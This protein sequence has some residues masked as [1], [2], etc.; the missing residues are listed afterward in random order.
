MQPIQVLGTLPVEVRYGDYVGTHKLRVVRGNVLNL[1]RRDWLEHIRL[2]W[3]SIKALNVHNSSLSV[4]Q[5]IKKHAPVFEPGL[6]TMKNFT[7]KLHLKEGARPCFFRSRPVFVLK[8]AVEQ[9]ITR[10]VNNDT[11]RPV[12]YS[13]WAAPIV[14]VPKADGTLRICGPRRRPSSSA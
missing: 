4:Q 3:S 2:D 7:A 14:P 9:E 1:L 10:L 5:L 12:E 11:L 13:E 6:G 8:E